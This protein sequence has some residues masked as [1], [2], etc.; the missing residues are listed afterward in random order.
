MIQAI[1]NSINNSL[2]TVFSI[3]FRERLRRRT[4][5]W[6]W[7]RVE[8]TRA[9]HRWGLGSNP[10]GYENNIKCGLSLLLIF[11]L[12]S[13]SN[14]LNSQSIWNCRKKNP[15]CNA[16]IKSI[17]IILLNSSLEEWSV[18]ISSLNYVGLPETRQ[19]T[20][21]N[22][23]RKAASSNDFFSWAIPLKVFDLK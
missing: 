4:D 7:C 19:R 8:C 17:F 16:A 13:E 3:K 1:H 20:I 5:E 12:S 22:T 23:V 6:V 11:F 2:V 9:F 14:N 21:C 18:C 15:F 10:R